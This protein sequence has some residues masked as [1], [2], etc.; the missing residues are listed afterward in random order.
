[1][2]QSAAAIARRAI[3]DQYRL[4]I[5]DRESA[6]RTGAVSGIR[7]KSTSVFQRDFDASAFQH[8]ENLPQAIGKRQC[9]QAWR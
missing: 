9:A 8:H 6:A 4:R 3:G 2:H 5:R 1:M 7:G